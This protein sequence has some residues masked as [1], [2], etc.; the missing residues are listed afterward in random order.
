MRDKNIWWYVIPFVLL[1][2][3]I[4]VA[5]KCPAISYESSIY[6]S[7]PLFFW[8]LVS[9]SFGIGIYLCLKTN[10][11][12]IWIVLASNLVVLSLHIL[13]GYYFLGMSGDAG[14]HLGWIQDIIASGSTNSNNYYPAMHYLIAWTSQLTGITPITLCKIAPLTWAAI[15]FIFLWLCAKEILPPKPAIF[16]TFLGLP[17]LDGYFVLA[18]P[19]VL[20]NSLFPVVFYVLLKA[21]KSAWYR[22]LLVVVLAVY[23]VM[24]PVA[25]GAVA[26]LILVFYFIKPFGSQR[27][28]LLCFG[29]L[30]IGI[31]WLSTFTI[32]GNALRSIQGTTLSTSRVESTT[33]A[34]AYADAHGAN[35]LEHFLK[36]YGFVL[37]YGVLSLWSLRYAVKYNPKLFRVSIGILVYGV[38][39]VALYFTSIAFDPLRLQF[40]V[41]FLLCFPT[42]YGLYTLW[43]KSRGLRVV[44]SIL[45]CLIFANGIMT[46]YYSTYLLQISLH[47]TQGEF[48]GMKWLIENKN[49]DMASGG[50]YYAPWTFATVILPE[51]ERNVRYDLAPYHLVD[52]PFHLGYDKHD[53]IGELYK[54]DWYLVVNP[55]MHTVYKSVYPWLESQRLTDEDFVKLNT[56]SNAICLYD[57]DDFSVYYIR[58]KP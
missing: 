8:I 39:I 58:C 43:G 13:R 37:V 56:D 14:V 9:T 24:H 34:V 48:E 54:T 40:N 12:G 1:A 42:G 19:S 26:I 45:V 52:V 23:V 21:D 28:A 30:A 36:R 55:A 53:S 15:Y 33:V 35:V 44:L 46:V 6:E 10:T 41:I 50:W 27:Y 20:A 3:A 57:K 11:I 16:A 31:I 49:Q 22:A 25:W 32:W 29:L 47:T 5:I 17:F 2:I 4:I 18:V 7:T 38:I 51:E